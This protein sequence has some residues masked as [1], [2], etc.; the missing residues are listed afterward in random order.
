MNKFEWTKKGNSDESQKVEI[1][2]SEAIHDI[3]MAPLKQAWLM[4]ILQGKKNELP[5]GMT[6]YCFYL[7]NDD[8]ELLR[9]AFMQAYTKLSG[10][11]TPN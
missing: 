11:N 3:I 10:F 1:T 6:Y 4:P 2:V 9:D 7:P 5:N 8:A